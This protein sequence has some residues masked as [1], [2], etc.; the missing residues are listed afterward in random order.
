MFND[1]F[2]NQLK[3]MKSASDEGAS[4]LK[5]K[6]VEGSSGNGLIKLKLDGNYGLKELKIATDI[7]QMEVGDLEDFLALALQNAIEQVNQL[8]EK[9]MLNSIGG[10]F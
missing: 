4:R 6:V 9:E 1:D 8:R 7:Q 5:E 3:A 2:L 10:M